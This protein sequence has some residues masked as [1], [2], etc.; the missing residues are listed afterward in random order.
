MG[1]MLPRQ[2]RRNTRA[3]RARGTARKNISLIGMGAPS[4]NA[5]C[6]QY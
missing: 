6:F 1:A 4:K 5:Y 2:L 3:R